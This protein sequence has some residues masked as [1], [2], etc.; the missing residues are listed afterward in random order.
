MIRESLAYLKKSSD[1]RRW[2]VYVVRHTAAMTS[3]LINLNL[4]VKV[5][6]CKR[7]L[8]Q[9]G[10]GPLEKHRRVL[11][12]KVIVTPNNGKENCEKMSEFWLLATFDL[13]YDTVG[14]IL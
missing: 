1:V 13:L 9:I 7:V 2:Y 3:P 10:D 11:N 8:E 14:T 12:E 5:S 6:N 4:A